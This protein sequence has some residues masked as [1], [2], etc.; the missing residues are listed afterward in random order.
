MT[1]MQRVLRTASALLLAALVAMPALGQTL[2]GSITG[3]I[4]DQQGAVLPGVTVTLM[5]KQGTQT[6]VTD[7]AGVY[8]FPALE[9]G[10]YAV[11]AELAGFNKS[12]TPNIVISPGK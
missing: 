4:K 5:G 9:V 10:T 1:H 11:T 3:T 12:Q 8:R 7:S 2:T 6:Q